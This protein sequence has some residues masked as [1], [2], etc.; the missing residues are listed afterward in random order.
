MKRVAVAALLSATALGAL[1]AGQHNVN[2][3]TRRDGT[4][5]APHQRTNPDSSRTNNWS[6]RG[7]TNP[8]TGKEGTV[9]PY[10]PKQPRSR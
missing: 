5:V 3:H 8:Y 4:Y 10:A 2:G 1:A 6:S 9:D 7:N